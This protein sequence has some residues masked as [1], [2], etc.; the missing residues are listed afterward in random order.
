MLAW[1]SN[2]NGHLGVYAQDVAPDGSPIGGRVRM[3]NTSNMEIGQTGRTPIAARTGG[4]FF[5]AYPRGTRR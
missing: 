5:V 1:Y 2:A 4:G 3:P